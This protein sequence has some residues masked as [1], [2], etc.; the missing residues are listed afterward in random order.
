MFTANE[1]AEGR[2]VLP[3]GAMARPANLGS[4]GGAYLGFSHR[5][6][7]YMIPNNGQGQDQTEPGGPRNV[8]DSM[9]GR[10]LLIPQG[11]TLQDNYFSSSLG[12]KKVGLTKPPSI[13]T[14]ICDIVATAVTILGIITIFDVLRNW[15]GG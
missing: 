7:Q 2:S 12:V 1:L 10:N 11:T 8:C 14:R 4:R 15:L 3:Q 9:T 5:G 6:C 13:I